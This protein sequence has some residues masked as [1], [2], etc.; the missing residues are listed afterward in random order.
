MSGW[1]VAVMGGMRQLAGY[2]L[3]LP[4]L[5]GALITSLLLT[6]L[7]ISYW[8]Q[9]R[10]QRTRLPPRAALKQRPSV[11]PIPRLAFARQLPRQLTSSLVPSDYTSEAWQAPITLP[12][13]PELSAEVDLL[14]TLVGRDFV[15]AWF[16]ELSADPSFPRSVRAQIAQALDCLAERAATVDLAEVLVGGWLPL[17]TRQLRGQRSGDVA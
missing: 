11:P 7:L 10:V 12:A 5:L 16:G 3:M 9:Q 15:D 4:I 14:L 2:A 6:N 1:A 17:V 13:F 8:F